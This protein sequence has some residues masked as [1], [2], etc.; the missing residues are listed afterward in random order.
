MS[1]IGNIDG[2]I[3]VNKQNINTI[4]NLKDILPLRYKLVIPTDLEL[5]S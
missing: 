3:P 1:T 4:C 2:T 5:G